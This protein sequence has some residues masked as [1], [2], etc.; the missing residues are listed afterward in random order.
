MLPVDC[1]A[2]TTITIIVQ[3]D[4]RG[5]QSYHDTIGHVG[6]NYEINPLGMKTYYVYDRAGTLL[7]ITT[8]AYFVKKLN[9]DLFGAVR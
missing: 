9:Q 1:A 3:H 2:S 4:Q 8:R 7:P 5:T 6:C